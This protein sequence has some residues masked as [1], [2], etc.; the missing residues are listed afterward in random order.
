MHPV[1][2][3]TIAILLKVVFFVY[4]LVALALATVYG[5]TRKETWIQPGE[6]ERQRLAKGSTKS[7]M[8]P[9]Y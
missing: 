1:V 4:A 7:A 8:H 2:S 5:L 3:Q 6:N 9:H